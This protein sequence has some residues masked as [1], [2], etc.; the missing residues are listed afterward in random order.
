MNDAPGMRGDDSPHPPATALVPEL[1]AQAEL[2][3]KIMKS[4]PCEDRC[5]L[6]DVRRCMTAIYGGTHCVLSTEPAWGSARG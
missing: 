3:P 5:P 1:F 4:C 6:R 2:G